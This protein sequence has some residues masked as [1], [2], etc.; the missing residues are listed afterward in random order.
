LK[1]YIQIK[2]LALDSSI[3]D[4]HESLSFQAK[5]A[6]LVRDLIAKKILLDERLDARIDKAIK[7]LAQ[8][9]TFK[10]IIEAS[11]SQKN[12]EQR[13]ISNHQQ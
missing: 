8:L 11:A 12:N 10:Q 6:A 7:R 9:K 5:K 3:M 2:S 4:E 13:R 1:K